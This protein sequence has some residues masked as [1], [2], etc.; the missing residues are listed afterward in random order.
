VSSD[1]STWVSLSTA[2]VIVIQKKFEV[3]VAEHSFSMCGRSRS[4]IGYPAEGNPLHQLDV[5]GNFVSDLAATVRA[6][7]AEQAKKAAAR[8]DGLGTAGGGGGAGPTG[9]AGEGGGG[10][11]TIGGVTAE[12][13]EAGLRSTHGRDG[14]TTA[15]TV[16]G[17]H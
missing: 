8:A 11:I 16:S 13:T 12:A 6:L 10:G 4:T 17:A 1:S 7:R 15:S 9:G 2:R 5:V 14:L 3:R